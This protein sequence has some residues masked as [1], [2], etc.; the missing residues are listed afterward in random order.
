MNEKGLIEKPVFENL[1]HYL[2]SGPRTEV[3]PI[4]K[5]LSSRVEGT[6][7]EEVAKDLL[8]KMNK[9]TKRLKNVAGDERKFKRSAEEILISGERTGCCDSSTL[10]TALCRSRGIPALQVIT[11]FVPEALEKPERFTTGHFYTACFIK[12]SKENGEWKVVDSDKCQITEDEIEFHKLYPNNRNITKRYYAIAYSRDYSETGID[13]IKIDSIHNMLEVQ[14]RAF[15]E[16][17]R[18]DFEYNKEDNKSR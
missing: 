3:T 10:Y 2:T 6:S 12:D 5:S 18:D 8:I 7:E 14:R 13:G 4:I 9:A 11:I 15:A 1:G 16:C 17:E